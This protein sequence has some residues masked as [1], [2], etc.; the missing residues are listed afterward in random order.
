MSRSLPAL[1]TVACCALAACAP[2]G[3]ETTDVVVLAYQSK[4]DRYDRH[5]VQLQ[6][7]DD[8]VALK[9]SIADVVGRAEID[10]DVSSVDDLF[11]EKGGEVKA[12]F[13]DVDG[14]LIPADFH[15]LNMVTA[16]YNLERAALFFQERG[17]NLKQYGKKRLY[18][19][20]KVN[21]YGEQ[22]KDNAFF[23]SI[24][25][26]FAVLPFD[27]FQQLPLAINLGIMGHEFSHSVLNDYVCDSNP[28]CLINDPTYSSNE[29][30][31]VLTAF[32]EGIADFMGAAITCGEDFTDC[33]PNFMAPS[34]PQASASAR[35]LSR[36]WCNTTV[37]KERLKDDVNTFYAEGHAYV[38]GTVLASALWRAV[39]ELDATAEAW[40]LVASGVL[41]ALQDNASMSG[42]RGLAEA[43]VASGENGIFVKIDAKHLTIANALNAIAGKMNSA[44]KPAVCAA[45][46]DRFFLTERDLPQCARFTSFVQCSK[47]SIGGAP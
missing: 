27:E 15:S 17:L 38:L 2:S 22:L 7:I 4:L 28:Y 5:V 37:T 18:Y 11:G 12:D 25:G 44:V 19:F 31:N 30:V 26:G 34:M 6:T 14:V 43:E 20:P 10:F 16:Y 33:D 9:G 41:D 42:I 3:D 21:M 35:D 46:L 24:L 39:D 23:S 13:I 45:F 36:R 47:K 29:A 8:I 1:M 40:K 32:D